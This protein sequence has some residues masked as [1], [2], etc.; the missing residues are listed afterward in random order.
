MRECDIWLYTETA[1]RNKKIAVVHERGA[2]HIRRVIWTAHGHSEGTYAVVPLGSGRTFYQAYKD[3]RKKG[4][5]R[6]LVS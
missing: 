5:I 3:A 4:R 1:L 6:R 2:V